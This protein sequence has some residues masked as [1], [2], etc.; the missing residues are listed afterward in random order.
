MGSAM[1]TQSAGG[2]TEGRLSRYVGRLI[3][4]QLLRTFFSIKLT[5]SERELAELAVDRKYRPAVTE[6]AARTALLAPAFVVL[7]AEIV[8]SVLLPTTMVA[9]TAWFAVSLASMKKKFEDFGTELTKDLFVAFT[10]SLMMLML[11]TMMMLTTELWKPH[12]PGWTSWPAVKWC[13]AALA[14]LVV[15]TLLFSIFKG[16]LKYDINDAMLSGQNE[17]AERYFKQSL[18]LLYSTSQHLRT[19]VKIEVANYYL[20][21]CF[22]E[23]F[24]N[25]KEVR[26]QP[27]EAKF[28]D[29]LIAQANEL[30]RVPNKN[31]QEADEIVLGLAK[32]FAESCGTADEIRQHRSYA[33]ISFELA[34]LDQRNEEQHVVD[35]RT[36][37]ILLEMTNLVETFGASLFSN[38]I[39]K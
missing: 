2:S 25:I 36:S 8:V 3:A 32:S 30:M 37:V 20:G 14:I 33:A 1:T 10:L 35:V 24:H 16:S 22:Y 4:K 18:S 29:E 12:L 31:Q 11:A 27:N 39:T 13:S 6:A 15:G 17:V 34:C 26:D 5:S 28:I 19:G 7:D 23:L 21:L 38:N 9:G